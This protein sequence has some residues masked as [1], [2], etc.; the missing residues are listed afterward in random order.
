MYHKPLLIVGID[1][2]ITVGYAV[3]DIRGKVIKLRSSKQLELNS[4]ISEIHSIG[5]VLLVGVDKM[6]S[7]SLVYKFATKLGAKLV[8]PKNDMRTMEKNILTKGLEFANDHERDSLASALFAYKEHNQLLK[9]I[10]KFAEAHNKRELADEITSLVVLKGISIQE[11]SDMLEEPEEEKAVKRIIE[12]KQYT[13]EDFLDL[14]SKMKKLRRDFS[15]LRRYNDSLKDEITRLKGEKRYI[16]GITNRTDK[17]S[18]EKLEFKERRIQTYDSQMRLKDEAIKLLKQRIIALSCF[19]SNLDEN[20]LLK[21]L[22]NLGYNEFELKNPLLNIQRG[23]IL[24]VNDITVYSEKTIQQLRNKV[25][26]I[27][28][29]NGRAKSDLPFILVRS[30]ELSLNEEEHFALANKKELDKK[31]SSYELLRK[32]IKDYKNEI[33]A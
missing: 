31:T 6:N 30:D 18:E 4:L 17:R 5:R 20:Y 19:L 27:I 22:D 13:E 15:L 3:L 7:P 2:G 32:I 14:Y 9:K 1:P 25:S 29:R 26:I 28:Y 8:S 24:L 21:K 12:Q 11:A 10:D 33:S 23:D 16:L